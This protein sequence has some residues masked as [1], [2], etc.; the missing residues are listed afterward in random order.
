MKLVLPTM[1]ILMLTGC[2][3][4]MPQSGKL[5]DTLT[6]PNECLQQCQSLPLLTTGDDNDRREWMLQAVKL[7]SDC[8]M[9]KAECKVKLMSR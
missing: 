3:S 2:S 4:L 9:S 1:L 7:H 8:T 6:I 5:T